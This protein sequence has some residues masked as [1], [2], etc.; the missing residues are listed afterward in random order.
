MRLFVHVM[1]LQKFQIRFSSWH[2]HTGGFVSLT[3]KEPVT[4][5]HVPATGN[6]RRRLANDVSNFS[7][8]F[9]LQIPVTVNEVLAREAAEALEEVF[10]QSIPTW[11]IA[12]IGGITGILLIGGTSYYITYHKRFCCGR[13]T[14]FAPSGPPGDSAIRG[15]LDDQIIRV[16]DVE[17]DDKAQNNSDFPNKR[18]DQLDDVFLNEMIARA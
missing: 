11:A 2:T 13:R 9:E 7:M 10:M 16:N 6:D 12:I 14:R 18:S 4:S 5:S 8:D 15:N 3:S 17:L 1:A